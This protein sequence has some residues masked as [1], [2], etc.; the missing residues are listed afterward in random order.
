MTSDGREL[1]PIRFEVIRN[2]LVAATDE[3]AATLRRSAYSTNVKTRADFSCSFFDAELRVVAQAFTQPVHL[4]SLVE[5]V[6][7][8]VRTFGV[9]RL[10]PRDMLVTNDPYGGGVH[11][12]DITV[13]APVHDRSEVVG[14]LATLAHHVDVGGG[15]PMATWAIAIPS[16]FSSP[17]RSLRRRSPV[18]SRTRRLACTA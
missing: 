16:S 3:M 2:A 10:E 11:L 8:A 12:N 4:G 18:R 17:C 9:D 7:R 13:I 14:Y 6:P 5:L 1:H 15:A